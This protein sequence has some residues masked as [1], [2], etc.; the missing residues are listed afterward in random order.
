MCCSRRARGRVGYGWRMSP[1]VIKDLKSFIFG[2]DCDSVFIKSLA[3]VT[4][5]P[6]L[7]HGLVSFENAFCVSVSSS[8]CIEALYL[9]NDDEDPFISALQFIS[10]LRSFHFSLDPFDRSEEL[11][12]Q[13]FRNFANLYL[14]AGEDKFIAT[15]LYFILFDLNKKPILP[16]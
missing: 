4:A 8:K 16:C 6:I 5:F 10:V 11:C 1:R 3:F 12:H 2:W 7:C 15:H 9:L 13:I 14:N